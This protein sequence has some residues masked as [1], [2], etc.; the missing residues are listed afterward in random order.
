MKR[1]LILTILILGVFT[2]SIFAQSA[3][4]KGDEA[5]DSY[6]YESAVEYYTQALPSI[7]NL[8]Q[9][10]QITYRIG[11]AHYQMRNTVMAEEF[12]AKS[13]KSNSQQLT[14]EARLYYG[15]T[16]RMNGKYEDAIEVYETYLDIVPDDY[17]A[18]TAIKSCKEVPVW[19]NEQTRWEVSNMAYFNSMKND[20]T[21]VWGD[22]KK[23]TVLFTTTRE[24]TKSDRGNN[25][26]SGQRFAD[27]FEVKVDRKGKW[28]EATPIGGSVNTEQDEGRPFVTARGNIMYFTRCFSGQK[29]DIPCK[30]FKAQKRGKSWTGDVELV[31]PGFEG[32]DVAYPT[33]SP[34]ELTMYFC[35]KSPA[36][37]GGVDIYKMTRTNPKK[38]EWGEPI[39]LGEPI[40]TAGDEAYPYIKEDGT[41]YF[42]SDGHVGMGGY[43]LYTAKPRKD[44]GFEEPQ[45]LRPPINSSSDDYGIM[46]YDKRERGY[47][48]STRPGGKG[49]DDIYFFRIPPL[50]LAVKGVVRDTT[51]E[52]FEFRIK[53][54]KIQLLNEAGLVASY[55]TSEDGTFFFENLEEDV[56]YIL[57]ASL[58]SDYFANTYTFTTREIYNDTTIE[59]NINLAQIPKVITLPNIEYDRGK[60]TL[61]PESTVS[62][63]G[64]V[65][66]LNDNP[67]LTIELRAHTDFIGIDESNM[68][69]SDN[70]A[71][72]C[73]DY[74]VSKGIA[75]ERLKSRGFGESEPRVVDSVLSDKYKFIKAGDILTEGFIVG[76]K[77][78]DKQEICHQ[79]NRRTEFAVESKTF[80]LQPGQDPFELE[81]EHVIRKGDAEIELE[82]DEF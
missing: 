69:L 27:I 59:R 4:K 9:Y 20:L 82:G 45:N 12:F 22:K 40:N 19:E 79:L 29:I 38:D 42:S 72:S 21:P 46:F 7:K 5:F 68:T 63:D 16:L 34:D 56:D 35:A 39:N 11:F 30:I 37:Y 25:E 32:L 31:I 6:R 36:G 57:K 28:S 65:K 54:V 62:L 55:E 64:L 15:H 60:A 41:L 73:V 53:G 14:P 61:R 50:D 23:T 76:L 81:N 77:S 18:K 24:G 43:D 26:R 48:T 74:L 8:E 1:I 75:A 51:K 44:G 49:L 3:V 71:K 66:T 33:L 52:H 10:S 78:K 13:L 67:H 2:T 80:G 47:F 17:R 70:R 58:G